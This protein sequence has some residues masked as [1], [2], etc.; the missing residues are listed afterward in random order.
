MKPKRKSDGTVILE[1]RDDLPD[2]PASLGSMRANKTASWRSI[3]PF[4]IEAQCKR[5]MLCW[6]F[7]PEPAISPADPPV[8]DYDYCK[9]CGICIAEC[10]YGAIESENE[11]K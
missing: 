11:G 2:M 9:G 8:I 3:R 4:I 7:C 1:N 6:K 5:C 10:P